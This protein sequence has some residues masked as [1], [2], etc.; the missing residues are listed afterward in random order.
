M[1]ELDQA[2]VETHEEWATRKTEDARKKAYTDPLTGS[3]P[4]FAQAI[5]MDIMGEAGADEVRQ[6]AVDR[7]N[8]IKSAIPWP[9]H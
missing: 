5:R 4:L 1:N 9:R 8:E 7:Y 6:Q 3:D 2:P